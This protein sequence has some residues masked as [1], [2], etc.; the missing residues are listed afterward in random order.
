MHIRPSS[1]GSLPLPTTASAGGASGSMGPATPI[2]TATR[3]TSRGL[4]GR[5]ATGSSAALN[6][7]LP[8]NQFVDRADRRRL[9]AECHAGPARRHRLSAELDDQRRR[10]HRS[11]AVPHGGDVRPHGRDR[12]EHA[13][14]DDPVLPVPQPQ[15][16]SAHAR[17]LLPR[18]SRSSTTRTRPT[19]PSIRRSS[20]CG[21][22]T[23]CGRSA[24]SRPTCST[25]TPD[26]QSAWPRGKTR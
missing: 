18:C 6:R 4:C 15:V 10:R 12:Q 19:S 13:R 8:Y 1:S 3:R 17:G 24:R 2:R 20:R 7:D 26:W 25:S 5:I 22:P 9:A 16:R 11:R 21:G 23:S 14:P